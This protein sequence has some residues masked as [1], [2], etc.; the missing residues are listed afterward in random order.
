MTIGVFGRRGHG[1]SLL[2]TYFLAI[3]QLA[4]I[5]IYSNYGVKGSNAVNL[6]Q[7]LEIEDGAIGLDEL[8]Q[9]LDSRLWG[10]K[11]NI[12]ITHW[13]QQQRKKNLVILWTAQQLGSME[14]RVRESSDY[15]IRATKTEDENGD[16]VF[17]YDIIDGYDMTLLKTIR[18][19]ERDIKWIYPYYDTLQYVDSL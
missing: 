12:F 18:A 13:Y 2:I 6:K 4:G 11:I 16:K 19:R 8:W 10:D 1:K 14:K 5:P 17:S 3:F 9:K 15:L 7:L